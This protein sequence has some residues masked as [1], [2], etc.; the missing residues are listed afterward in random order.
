MFAATQTG[1]IKAQSRH[2]TLENKIQNLGNQYYETEPY[3]HYL[4]TQQEAAR[5]H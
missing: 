4:Y 3:A 1:S 2:R 5:R